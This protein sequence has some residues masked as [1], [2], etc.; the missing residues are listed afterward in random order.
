MLKPSGYSPS[1]LAST[2]VRAKTSSTGI[3]LAQ[4]IHT[5]LSIEVAPG[6][7]ENHTGSSISTVQRGLVTVSIIGSPAS[8]NCGFMSI[9]WPMVI[10]GDWQFGQAW[11]GSF[12]PG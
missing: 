5:A 2:P 10:C 1:G 7:G 11:G 12:M 9:V 8:F 4:Q 3:L 6:R